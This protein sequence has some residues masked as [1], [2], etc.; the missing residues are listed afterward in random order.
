MLSN[1]LDSGRAIRMSIQVVNSFVR[2]RQ[3]IEH[4]KDI[5]A[6]LEKV[7]RGHERPASV[8]EIGGG[9]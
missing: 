7:E 9:Y 2:L 3:V 8:I 4:H 6:R 5:A 1:V